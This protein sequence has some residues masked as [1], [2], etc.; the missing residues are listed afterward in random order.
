MTRTMQLKM[1]ITIKSTEAGKISHA[2]S[3]GSIIN[4]GD[5]L[6]SL[7]LKDPSK[8]KKILPFEGELSYE[9][10][11]AKEKTTLQ[12]FRTARQSLELVMDGYVVE[13][14]PLRPSR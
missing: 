7:E 10:A 12:A 5:L 3:P 11:D 9:R 1:L 2:K 8:V 13:T 6:A 4:Q 14:E